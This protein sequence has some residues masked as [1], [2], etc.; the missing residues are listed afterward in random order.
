MGSIFVVNKKI[1][2][3][4]ILAGVLIIAMSAVCFALWP[5]PALPSSITRQINFTIFMPNAETVS[6]DKP[7][8]K[9]DSSLKLLSYNIN[10]LNT[11]AVVSMQPTPESFTDIPEVYK[12][13]V[14]TMNEEFKFENDLGTIYITRPSDLKGKQ[15]AVVNAKGTLLFIKPDADLTQDQWRQLFNSL[16]VEK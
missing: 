11:R 9:Y 5:K 15:A 7:S 6:I 13:I 1:A 16:D 2:L 14:T 10:T 3:S 4:F 8:I 12:K